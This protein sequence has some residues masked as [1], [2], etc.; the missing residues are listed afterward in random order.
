MKGFVNMRAEDL[1]LDDIISFSDGHLSLHG[2][3]LIIH[4]IQA[5]AQLRNDLVQTVGTGN[6]RRILTRFGYFWGEADA[7]GMDRI[8]EWDSTEEWLR[9]GPH[10]HR[11]QGLSRTDITDLEI[12]N[13]GKFRMEIEWHNSAE[14]EEQLIELG[15]SPVASCWI[16]IGYASGYASYCMGEPIYFKELKCRGRGD[17][18]CRAL[19]MDHDSWGEE[20][21]SFADD[22]QIGEIR[23]KI[24][25]LTAELRKKNAELARQ[26]RRMR[27]SG[28]F[29]MPDSPHL[30]SKAYGLVLDS[31]SR[32]AGFDSL[33]LITGESGVGKEVIARFIH[34]N[35]PRRNKDFGTINCGALPEELLSSELFGHKAG[36][37]TGAISDRT[38]LLEQTNGG[39][40]LLDEIGD[41]SPALQLTLLRVLQEKQIRRVGENINRDVDV[42]IIAA[43]NRDLERDVRDGRFRQDLFYRLRVVEINI[44][45][46]RKRPEDII[47][48]ARFL[49]ERIK[50][51]LDL[52]TLSL[53]P[54]CIRYLE[55]YFWP[56]NVRELENAIER[57]AVMSED[58]RIRVEHLPPSILR[59]IRQAGP[60]VTGEMRRLEDI[61]RRHIRRVLESC[62]GNRSRAARVL[63]IGTTTLWR[64]LK[65]WDISG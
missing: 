48:L 1:K 9:A 22:M 11:L 35:S 38:G 44:P 19:G 46:L 41:I 3:R 30:P 49:T 8:M 20:A 14:A 17:E 45:P 37:F 47:P 39:T 63:G 29:Y 5:M 4:D 7:A 50:K 55:S 40:I 32:V 24:K 51:R 15:P 61:E 31:A 34:R 33:V 52:E 43:T 25:E 21:K 64:K 53:D 27:K 36:S 58:G 6:T 26:R 18:L 16:L 42:R 57:A 54:E 10:L 62:G 13:S 2:R 60:P 56:G 65:K 12:G 28:S 59:V 23:G